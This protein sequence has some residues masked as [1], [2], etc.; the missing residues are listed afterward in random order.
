METKYASV[1][2]RYHLISDEWY[3]FAIDQGEECLR[4][5]HVGI[6]AVTTKL[7][8]LFAIQSTIITAY[9][10]FVF[11][12]VQ[13]ETTP[14]YNSIVFMGSGAIVMIPL[15]ISAVKCVSQLRVIR[16]PVNGSP[17]HSTLFDAFLT[18]EQSKNHYKAAAFARI[19]DLDKSISDAK[20]SVKDKS[21][22]LKKSFNWALG[23]L[24]L[25]VVALAL[26][27]FVIIVTP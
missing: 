2:E 16:I 24:I 5:I 1:K 22:G 3:K 10:G 18:K 6:D 23:A 17:P 13:S 14:S 21:N 7:F 12:C 8:W 25:S 15:I 11:S 20:A 19:R 9:L 4:S 27:L 26:G